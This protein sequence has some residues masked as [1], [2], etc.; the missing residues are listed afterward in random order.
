MLE[1]FF[2]GVVI[3]AVT[4]IIGGLISY[5]LH[6][7]DGDSNPRHI[8]G[9]IYLTN[10]GLFALGT[11][12]VVNSF[13]SGELINALITGAGVFIGFTAAFGILLYTWVQMQDR[14]DSSPK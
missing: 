6:L 4:S 9:C 1:A 13:F 10:G 5:L 8:I 7:R 14:Q 2:L 12:V 3:G 11:V